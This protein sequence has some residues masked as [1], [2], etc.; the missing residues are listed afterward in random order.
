MGDNDVNKFHKEKPNLLG[1]I[2]SAGG[3]GFDCWVFCALRHPYC[4]W[5]CAFRNGH[6]WM[7]ES[8]EASAVELGWVQELRR[9]RKVSYFNAIH[10]PRSPPLPSP[11]TQ[12]AEMVLGGP[13]WDCASLKQRNCCSLKSLCLLCLP[14]SQPVA[15]CSLRASPLSIVLLCLS[16]GTVGVSLP[17]SLSVLGLFC[18]RRFCCG[19][20][21]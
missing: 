7:G 3:W 17:A 9:N 15:V 1:L 2:K 13:S 6:G 8:R 10:L 18:H 20:K 14:P 5:A 12:G 16:S 11:E 21:G 4:N 19:I